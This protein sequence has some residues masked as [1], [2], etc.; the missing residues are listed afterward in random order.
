MLYQKSVLCAKPNNLK[1]E[2]SAKNI[3]NGS[4]KKFTDGVCVNFDASCNENRVKCQMP[5][6][7]S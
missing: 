3:R 2:L 4:K 5:R 6:G 7:H 1:I